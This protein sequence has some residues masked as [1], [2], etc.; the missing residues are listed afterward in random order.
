MGGKFIK[1]KGVIYCFTN[2]ING[3]KYVGKT[4]NLK[5]RIY[6]HKY[7][8]KNKKT[9]S[10]FHLAIIKYGFDS[11]DLEILWEGSK[12]EL[13]DKEQYYINKLNTYKDGY[14]LTLGGDDGYSPSDCKIRARKPRPLEM[15]RLASYRHFWHNQ[16]RDWN[17]EVYYQLK[18]PYDQLK[19]PIS[20]IIYYGY[21]NPILPKFYKKSYQIFYNLLPKY[22]VPKCIECDSTNLFFDDIRFEQVCKD[23]GLVL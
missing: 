17:K 13:N 9:K 14:N 6:A 7:D 2:K 23:C 22:R 12:V 1:R 20:F 16:K 8:A 5:R 15:S 18:K 3:K 19:N 10:A 4:V 11:F 21:L